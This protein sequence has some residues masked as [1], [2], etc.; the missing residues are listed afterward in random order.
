MAKVITIPKEI[1]KKGDLVLIPRQEYERILSILKMIPKEQLW[2]WT[3]EWQRKERE[4]EEDIKKGRLYG[5]FISGKELLKSL[6]SK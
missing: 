2:F 5:P 6:R 4:A 3:K 1:I